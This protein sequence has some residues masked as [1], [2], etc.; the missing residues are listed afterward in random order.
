VKRIRLVSSV[1]GFQDEVRTAFSFPADAEF[2]LHVIDGEDSNPPALALVPCLRWFVC[3]LLVCMCVFGCV[4]C[5]CPFGHRCLFFVEPSLPA[6]GARTDESQSLWHR[7]GCRCLVAASLLLLF[8]SAVISAVW[9]LG[10]AG[11]TENLPDVRGVLV[12][13]R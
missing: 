13:Q 1:K 8:C 7:F 3:C 12:H 10:A 11:S 6:A 4:V 5:L 2:T 9:S